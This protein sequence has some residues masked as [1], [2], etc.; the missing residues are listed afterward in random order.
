MLRAPF[1]VFLILLIVFAGACSF[2]GS[3]TDL[4]SPPENQ[5]PTQENASEG[6][7][8]DNNPESMTID[9][10]P[11]DQVD[12]VAAVLYQA[13]IEGLNVSGLVEE[14]YEA[15]GIPVLDPET[16]MDQIENAVNNQTPFALES[17]MELIANA[18]ASGM[19][20]NLESFIAE[21]NRLGFYALASGGEITRDYLSRNLA[22]LLEQSEYAPEEVQ[23]A[24]ILALGRTRSGF[25]YGENLDPVWGDDLLDPLQ[26]A[27]LWNLLDQVAAA[28]GAST[29]QTVQR[30]SYSSETGNPQRQGP[31]AEFIGALGNLANNLNEYCKTAK[32]FGHQ[33]TL[34]LSENQIYRQTIG[35]E[36]PFASEA[37][38]TL[39]FSFK[40]VTAA[41]NLPVKLN[42]P[43][44]PSIGPRPDIPVSWELV[45]SGTRGASLESLGVFTPGGPTNNQGI[46]LANYLANLEVVP[47]Y[48]QQD[49]NTDAAAGLIRVTAADLYPGDRQVLTVLTQ[50]AG[51]QQ[52]E[53]VYRSQSDLWVW[54][55]TFPTVEWFFLD[56]RTGLM[57]EGSSFS[58]DGVNWMGT[59]EYSHNLAGFSVTTSAEFEFTVP[60]IQLG[61]SVMSDPIEVVFGGVYE[62]DDGPIPVSERRQVWLEIS[63]TEVTMNFEPLGATVTIDGQTV[64]FPGAFV[65]RSIPANLMTN[66]ACD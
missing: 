24:L 1:I 27:L 16:E 28:S 43:D 62:T 64:P 12:E 11:I 60:E 38:F 35:S 13:V 65:F 37:T 55:Y 50:N 58:C 44:L 45:P 51:D 53:G 59:H 10:P 52:A 61:E 56:E 46:S 6:D 23:T 33:S 49:E 4:S 25:L 39:E 2:G 22:Y 34:T 66:N 40:P 36:R 29:S 3:E 26:S 42:C 47:H 9:L 54:Y 14:I 63:E 8:R 7:S 5:I 31:I 41:E 20:L 19:H 21:I 57:M 15:L 30:I 18:L 48:L 32:I 17:Q